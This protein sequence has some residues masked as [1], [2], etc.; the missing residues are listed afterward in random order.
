MVGNLDSVLVQQI[1]SGILLM[2]CIIFLHGLFLL[3]IVSLILRRMKY[4]AAKHRHIIWLF[5]LYCFIA[6]PLISMYIPSLGIHVERIPILDDLTFENSRD[7]RLAGYSSP[8]TTMPG[9]EEPYAIPL[10]GIMVADAHR[11][12][13][14]L[15]VPTLAT[16]LWLAGVL[17]Y[18][19]R[20]LA[21][22]IG[23]FC[24]MKQATPV[25]GSRFSS[26]FQDLSSRLGI[27]QKVR[28]LKSNQCI[29]PFTCC[30]LK[31][32]IVL[33]ADT[34]GW[35]E[36]RLR[37][38]LL[39][40]LVHIRRRDHV[41]RSIARFVC[42]LLWFSPTV[43]IV[44][45][46]IQIEEEKACDAAVIGNGVR[47]TDYAGHL[48]DIAR[49]SRGRVLSVMLQHSFGRKGNLEPRI[50]NI[51][52]LRGR[53]EQARVGA[54]SRILVICFLCL[55]ILHVVN[56]LSARGRRSL[57]EK[58]APVELLYGRW[59]TTNESWLAACDDRAS[60][61]VVIEPDGSFHMYMNP[62]CPEYPYMGTNGRFTFVDSYVDRKG[63]CY[64]Q[65]VTEVPYIPQT[66]HELWRIDPS[67][68]AL[69]LTWYY[70][71]FPA[72]IDPQ[73]VAYVLLHRE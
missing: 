9:D 52:R 7:S 3:F 49:S 53:G 35:S 1:S 36:E 34:S 69:E 73:S 68:S 8:R 50:R 4:M 39:H 64:Y 42:T 65:V 19:F 21:G 44:Y 47:V 5:M 27:R 15:Q 51:L 33:P 30:L 26:L 71:D 11:F 57:T 61:K 24:V 45:N 41:S 12:L 46:N 28:V 32:V 66:F 60:G 62:T 13:A 67:G 17:I 58:E 48:L 31:P 20:I 6:I 25:A 10:K 18:L 72:D 14:S 59:L 63:Y 23:L 22:R 70:A 55:V 54:L 37:V 16:L 56:P 38:V 43:W 29:T 40:E 2:L